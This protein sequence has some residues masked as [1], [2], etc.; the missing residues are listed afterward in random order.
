LVNVLAGADGR[1][2]GISQAEY[3]LNR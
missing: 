2:N 3:F 1:C